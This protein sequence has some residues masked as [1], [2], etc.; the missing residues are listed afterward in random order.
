LELI[1]ALQEQVEALKAENA[2]HVAALTMEN[3]ELLKRNEN[4]KAKVKKAEYM[5]KD[6]RNIGLKGLELYKDADHWL[7]DVD[8]G[9]M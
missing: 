8:N 2:A 1:E 9:L 3:V 6:I 5:I 7:D 4:L